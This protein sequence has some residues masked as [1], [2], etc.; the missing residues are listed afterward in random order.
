MLYS[1]RQNAK[2]RLNLIKTEAKVDC[3]NL[4]SRTCD[5]KLRLFSYVQQKK[6]ECN[7]ENLDCQITS[8]LKLCKN[9]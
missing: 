2:T 1:R 3:R 6:I 4:E 9:V 8:E 7:N 5:L